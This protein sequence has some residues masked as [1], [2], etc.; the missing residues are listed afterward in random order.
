MVQVKT[1]ST[2][3]MR[4]LFV[5][6][7]K[8][9]KIILK[10]ILNECFFYKAMT[11][12]LNGH[13]KPPSRDDRCNTLIL[14]CGKGERYSGFGCGKEGC[15]YLWWQVQFSTGP[16]SHCDSTLYSQGKHKSQSAQHQSCVRGPDW[17]GNCRGNQCKNS[18]SMT[19]LQLPQLKKLAIWVSHWEPWNF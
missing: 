17:D 1:I 10:I 12:A 5:C 8:I 13:Y 18:E 16:L 11:L 3:F 7:L 2:E 4:R 6:V 19:K 14:V 15:H 9:I